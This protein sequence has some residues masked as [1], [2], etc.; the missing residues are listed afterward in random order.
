M[1][2]LILFFSE[3]LFMTFIG[4]AQDAETEKKISPYLLDKFEEAEVF[5]HDGSRYQETINYNLLSNRFYFIDKTDH[6][7]KAVSN[8]QDIF[9]VKVKDRCFYQEK[10]Y[11]VEVLPTNP[12]LFVQYKVHIRKEAEKGAYGMP[13]ETSSIRTYGGFGSHGNRFEL[14]TEELIVGKRY[15][16]YWLEKNKKRKA[17]KSFKQFVKLYPEHKAALEQFIKEN[18]LDFDNVEHIKALCI[19][20]ESL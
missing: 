2:R 3:L 13:S 5:F 17:F 6:S 4:L 14:N 1:K 19:H 12:P 9:M 16:H 11:A 15:Q 20:A 7:V 18:Q 10:G 8:P